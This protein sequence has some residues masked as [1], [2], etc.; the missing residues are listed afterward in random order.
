M[1]AV[2]RALVAVCGGGGWKWMVALYALTALLMYGFGWAGYGVAL[3]IAVLL[4]RDTVL[5]L[6]ETWYFDD[7]VRDPI[8]PVDAEDAGR[9]A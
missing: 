9:G 4:Q 6:V 2:W 8:D 7:G 5:H 3:T 1:R